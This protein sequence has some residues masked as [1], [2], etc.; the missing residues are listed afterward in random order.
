MLLGVTVDRVRVL[1][2]LERTRLVW[3]ELMVQPA[4]QET[5]MLTRG[6]GGSL[7]V[8]IV[9]RNGGLY[10]G[11]PPDP[12]PAT[13]AAEDPRWQAVNKRLLRVCT[14]DDVTVWGLG[15]ALPRGVADFVDILSSE[16]AKSSPT[17]K[18]GLMGSAVTLAAIVGDEALRHAKLVELL[19]Y[20]PSSP[21]L[22]PWPAHV[23]TKESVS[24]KRRRRSSKLK[25][26]P[27]TKYQAPNRG[28]TSTGPKSDARL[29]QQRQ[30]KH[31]YE[32]Q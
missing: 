23:S 31:S 6:E 21:E 14:S 3:D 16:P 4:A 12:Q 20:D 24:K 1:P 28:Q 25:K 17:L 9:I 13:W 29:T 7:G 32:L 18:L 15:H 10:L 8:T 26:A 27:S 5:V 19:T 2:V 11:V 22:T 30:D